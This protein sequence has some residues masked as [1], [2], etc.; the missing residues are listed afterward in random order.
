MLINANTTKRKY[1][2]IEKDNS[3]PEEIH[4]ISKE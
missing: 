4:K 2:K 1:S 3:E